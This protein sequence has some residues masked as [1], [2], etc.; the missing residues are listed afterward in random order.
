MELYAKPRV[1]T[2]TAL[3]LG[4]EHEWNVSVYLFSVLLFALNLNFNAENDAKEFATQL[5]TPV[6]CCDQ[7]IPTTALWF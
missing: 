6:R 3:R 5:S 1:P 2:A 4:F 7:T